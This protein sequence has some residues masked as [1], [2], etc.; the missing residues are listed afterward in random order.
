[1]SDINRRYYFNSNSNL[2][3]F[4]LL[5]LLKKINLKYFLVIKYTTFVKK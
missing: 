1:M 2:L 3:N 5:F 4:N